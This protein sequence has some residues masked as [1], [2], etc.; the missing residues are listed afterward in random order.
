[1]EKVFY[2]DTNPRCAIWDNMWTTRTIEQELEACD[3]ETPP[4]DL[5]LSLIPKQGKIIDGGCG[6]GKWVIYLH[7]RGYDILGIDDNQ[8][9]VSR[10]K[11]FDP[12]LK[13]E[14]QD[15]LA[16]GYPD[17][18]FDAYISMGVV[19]HFEDGP[20]LALNEARRIVKPGGL[21]FVSVPTVNL[22]RS[23]IRR[24]LRNQI[25]RAFM[26]PS[27]LRLR[28]RRT[29]PAEVRSGSAPSSPAKKTK[30]YHF[31]EYRYC[32]SELEGFLRQAG[33]EIMETVPHDFYGSRDHA[34]GLV[35]DFPFLAAPNGANYRL[36]AVGKVVSRTLNGISPWIACSSVLCVGRRLE[37]PPP[38]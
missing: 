35:G 13:V 9:A 6:F 22:M 3:I 32:K 21:V 30:Y 23:I 33:F 34:A 24:P 18:S 7:R 2:F 11:E 31:T 27:F 14:K 29:P 25:K 15:I 5:F 16:T 38:K 20:Q 8:I 19:E 10:L 26:L 17:N 36:N 1:M 37:R 4:R 28:G 12:T